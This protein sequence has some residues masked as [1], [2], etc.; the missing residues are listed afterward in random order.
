MG[1]QEVL[2]SAAASAVVCTRNRQSS[3]AGGCWEACCGWQMSRN[4]G[5]SG[6]TTP[7]A[8]VDSSQFSL[9][10]PCHSWDSWDT[11]L[12]VSQGGRDAGPAPPWISHSVM[13]TSGLDEDCF[14]LP[15]ENG[16]L[17][18]PDAGPKGGV[19]SGSSLDM[20]HPGEQQ[21]EQHSIIPEADL[22]RQLARY[23]LCRA[24]AQQHA[25]THMPSIC[26]CTR[27]RT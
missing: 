5:V 10:S 13:Q 1:Q 4:D 18:R 23:G 11:V 15:N 16:P 25:C 9:S 12:R 21:N 27:T 24:C 20:G 19:A 2:L 3:R 22:W 7:I 6:G 14:D 26:T 8:S 17:L